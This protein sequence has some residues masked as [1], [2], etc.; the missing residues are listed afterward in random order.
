M[1]EVLVGFMCSFEITS[2]KLVM[3]STVVFDGRVMSPCDVNRATCCFFSFCAAFCMLTSWVSPSWPPTAPRGSSCTC[4]TSSSASLTRL[5]RWLETSRAFL[6]TVIGKAKDAVTNEQ[7][8][9]LKNSSDTLPAPR[10]NT[11]L[12]LQLRL[13]VFTVRFGSQLVFSA[14]V[15]SHPSQLLTL[16]EQC[17]AQTVNYKKRREERGGSV[18]RCQPALKWIFLFL[19]LRRLASAS[20]PRTFFFPAAPRA[21]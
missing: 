14:S 18:S 11:R 16:F 15:T 7:P 20:A 2:E 8:R 17:A 19:R 13:R 4:W 10:T 21:C 5:Q 6:C 1:F 12:Q 3:K 9:P